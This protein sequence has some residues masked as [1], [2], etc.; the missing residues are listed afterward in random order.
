VRRLIVKK[1]G[2][3]QN[4]RPFLT[5]PIRSVD[6]KETLLFL[7]AAADQFSSRRSRSRE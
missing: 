2:G 5:D 6:S 7:V 4:A 3:E 1:K